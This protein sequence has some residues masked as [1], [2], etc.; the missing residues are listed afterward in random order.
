MAAAEQVIPRGGDNARGD[1]RPRLGN[2]QGC[3]FQTPSLRRSPSR[4]GGNFQGGCF[5][6]PL[7]ER[8]GTAGASDVPIVTFAPS[9]K[10]DLKPRAQIF[11]G[12]SK[13][14]PGTLQAARVN[15]GEDGLTPPMCRG[16]RLGVSFT[17]GMRLSNPRQFVVAT[18][19]RKRST[20]R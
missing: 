5:Q 14:L 19:A 6:T 10:A 2:F 7:P 20:L 13:K 1:A 15:Y 16:A 8:A 3:V 17:E 11:I 9:D 18:T 4:E 12:A